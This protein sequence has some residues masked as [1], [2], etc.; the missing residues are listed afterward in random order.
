MH[1]GPVA[2]E[3]GA[4]GRPAELVAERPELVQELFPSREA[5]CGQSRAALGRVPAAEALDHGLRMDVRARIALELAHRR[6]AAQP[7]GAR[8]ELGENV[9]VRVAATHAGSEVGEIGGIDLH[10]GLT[11]KDRAD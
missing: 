8:L 3:I 1:R 4:R 11:A 2:L 6:G 10:G 7:C 9:G 5:A